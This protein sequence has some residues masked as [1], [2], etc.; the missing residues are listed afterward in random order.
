MD[1]DIGRSSLVRLVT[2]K[3]WREELESERGFKLQPPPAKQVEK[4]EK[5]K[6]EA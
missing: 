1:K 5:E 3:S 6:C 2:T 4:A